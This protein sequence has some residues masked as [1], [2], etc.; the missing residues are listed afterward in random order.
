M[1]RTVERKSYAN[2]YICLIMWINSLQQRA[3]KTITP[4]SANPAMLFCLVKSIFE[5]KWLF[6]LVKYFE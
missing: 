5:I 3:Q 1:Q 2:I 6:D 4:Q